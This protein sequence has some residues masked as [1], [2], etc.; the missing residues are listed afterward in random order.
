MNLILN[1]FRVDNE[2]GLMHDM[3]DAMLLDPK[4]TGIQSRPK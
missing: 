4:L 3:T 1:I 2:N